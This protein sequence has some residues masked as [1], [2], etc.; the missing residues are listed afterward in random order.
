MPKVLNTDPVKTLVFKDEE[1][2]PLAPHEVRVKT[3][4]SYLSAGTELARLNMA[5][6]S[7]EGD[8]E[9]PAR[10]I[11]YSMAGT[12]LETGAAITHVKKGQPVACIGNGAFHATEVVV[13]KNNVVPVPDGVSLREAA[14]AAMMC[15]ALEGVRKA[16]LELGEHALVIGAG[17]MGQ[18][19]AQMA[20]RVCSVTVLMDRN[21][22]RLKLAGAGVSAVV[23][24][25][26]AWDKVRALAAP[27]GLEAVFFC[28][29]GDAT[30]LYEKVKPLMSSAGDQVPHGR[31]SFPGG[32]RL[33]VSL[34]SSGGNLQFLSSSKAGPGYRDRAY[35]AG[36][37]YPTSY[38]KFPFTRNVRVLLGDVAAGRLKVAPLIT[39]EF[40]FEEARK[41]YEKLAAPDTDALAVLLKYE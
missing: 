14:P 18:F 7:G 13:A 35:E 39:H 17:L 9:I 26:D 32:A 33:T 21:P 5:P 38:V 40:P 11:G 31:M 29:G 10:P 27:Y 41:G 24:G 16:K 4:Y 8:R 25:D 30:A 12:V 34:A 19:V 23:A 15:F 6:H 1:R 2:K 3:V 28:F 20:A 37:E 22:A 36:D